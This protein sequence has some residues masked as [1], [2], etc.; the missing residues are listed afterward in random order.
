M[1]D[2]GFHAVH[3]IPPGGVHVT[4]SSDTDI[5]LFLDRLTSGVVERD[6]R[7][8]QQLFT[9]AGQEMAERADEYADLRACLS[10]LTMQ[11]P[12]LGLD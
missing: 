8:I 11:Q 6:T 3:I 10:A 9:H 7:A 5:T 4:A 2:G 12:G 1:A